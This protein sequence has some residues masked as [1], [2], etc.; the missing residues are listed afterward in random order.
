VHQLDLH[1]AKSFLFISY[2]TGDA[3]IAEELRGVLAEDGYLAWMAPH[4]VQGSRPWAEQISDAISAAAVTVVLLSPD[5]IASAHVARE[6]NLA[7]DRGKPILPVRIE[8]VALSGSLSYLLALVQ[9]IDAFPGPLLRYRERLSKQLAE[10]LKGDSSQP[11]VARGAAVDFT[12]RSD[13]LPVM[14]TSVIGRD[15]ELD[16]LEALVGSH[17]L[18]TLTGPGGVGKTR[19][20]LE[21]AAHVTDRFPEGVWLVELAAVSRPDL[22]GVAV[23]NALGL[24]E[25]PGRTPEETLEELARRKAMLIVLDNCEHLLEP[26]ARLVHRMVRA[27]RE[28]CFLTTSRE[29]LALPGE[30][31]RP[32][33]PLPVPKGEDSSLAVRENPAAALFLERAEAQAGFQ[34]TDEQLTKVA[35]LCRR[36]DG[37]PLALE[38]AAARMQ[39]LSL[40]DIEARLEGRFRLLNSGSLSVLPRQQ[41]L[42]AAI[43]WSYDLLENDE[44][45][46]FA[47]LAAFVDSFDLE[48]AEVTAGYPPIDREGVAHL[49]SRLVNR[50]VVTRVVSADSSRFRY[51]ESLREFALARLSDTEGE[52]VVNQRLTD[53]FRKWARAVAP[54]MRGPGQAR[55]YKRIER[56]LP[57]I[58]AAIAWSLAHQDADTAADIVCSLWWHWQVRGRYQEGLDLMGEVVAAQPSE[59]ASYASLLNGMGLFATEIDQ[60]DA[61]LAYLQAAENMARREGHQP[62]LEEILGNRAFLELSLGNFEAARSLLRAVIESADQGDRLGMVAEARYIEGRRGSWNGESGADIELAEALKLAEQVGDTW[63]AA[64]AAG[65]LGRTVILAG[66]IDRGLQLLNQSR[67]GFQALEDPISESIIATAEAIG[68]IRSARFAEARLSL[69]SGLEHSELSASPVQEYE[70]MVWVADWLEHLGRHSEAARLCGGL[71]SIANTVHFMAQQAEQEAIGRV[72]RTC[73]KALGVELF[74]SEYESGQRLDLP[75][76]LAFSRQVLTDTS[77]DLG[78]NS[79]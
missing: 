2:A 61:A 36:L 10:L 75:Q 37:L 21:L 18:T 11:G 27:G 32:V 41:T 17:R 38:L 62:L 72:E 64:A 19:L 20:A 9:W 30:K 77:E 71:K 1:D 31:V 56:E 33:E 74:R 55:L 69:R 57:N 65:I 52:T 34:P 42:E 25:Q 63:L 67:K 39:G 24:P 53:Y 78:V 7:L 26:V 29:P 58:R 45:T 22:V 43:A 12:P 6:V 16:E 73:R 23:R 50:S 51:L 5:A 68:Y 60:Y 79:F 14:L 70:T 4:N 59:G 3:A 47:R 28:T 35:A 54:D 40:E 46:V 48:A 76:L 44:R 8:E 15:Q 49:L 13:N 66:D